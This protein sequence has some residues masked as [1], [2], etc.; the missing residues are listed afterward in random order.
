MVAAVD[1]PTGKFMPPRYTWTKSLSKFSAHYAARKVKAGKG[2]KPASKVILAAHSGANIVVPT[3]DPDACVLLGADYPFL[4]SSDALR[5][6][7][8]ALSWA[9]EAF[10][11]STWRDALSVMNSIRERTSARQVAEEFGILVEELFE[12]S[13]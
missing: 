4:A 2:F 3:S 9:R 10:G 7:S 11:T 5:D 12:T 1:T 6:V 8:N 13:K